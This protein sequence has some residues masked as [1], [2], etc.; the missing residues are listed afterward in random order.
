MTDHPDLRHGNGPHH[1]RYEARLLGIADSE[2]KQLAWAHS[3]GQ[4]KDSEWLLEE[5][6]RVT[7]LMFAV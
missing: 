7:A 3:L 6:G 2:L 1:D 4:E 5:D